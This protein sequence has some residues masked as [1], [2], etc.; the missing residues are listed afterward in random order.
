MMRALPQFVQLS[1]LFNR[2]AKIQRSNDVSQRGCQLLAVALSVTLGLP[3]LA[4]P[5]P[6]GAGTVGTNASGPAGQSGVSQSGSAA[7]SPNG[8]LQGAPASNAAAVA[9]P[10][11][12]NQTSATPSSSGTTAPANAVSAPALVPGTGEAAR[13]S[14][15][16]AKDVALDRSIDDDEQKTFGEQFLLG[17]SIELKLPKAKELMP[18]GRNLPPIRLEANYTEPISLKDAV[19]YAVALFCSALWPHC[20]TIAR[21]KLK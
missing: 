18:L 1:L 21:P 5:Q 3:A 12:Q 14:N 11:L 8:A 15:L 9:T 20:T 13:P 16:P 6:G 4:Q 7:T 2:T 19:N 10:S 17:E